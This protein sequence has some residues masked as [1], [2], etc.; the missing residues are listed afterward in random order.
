MYSNNPQLILS[1][2]FLPLSW[3]IGVPWEHCEDV[4]T[5]IGL[6]TVV[7]EF[8]AYQRL[9]ELKKLGKLTPRVEGI[10]TFAICG[11]ANPGSVGIMMGALISMAPESRQ[12]IASV[13]VRAFISGSAVCFM[14]AAIAGNIIFFIP[15]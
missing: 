3:I 12:T 15:I 9:G 1:K 8:V 11:F 4:A 5:L 7:N 14:T 6:K 13:V 2:V 10:A